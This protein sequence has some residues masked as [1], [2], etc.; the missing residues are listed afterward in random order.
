MPGRVS[1]TLTYLKSR[2][3]LAAQAVTAIVSLGVAYD[4]ARMPIQV[5]DSV[6]LLLDAQQSPSAWATFRSAVNSYGYLRPAFFG[7][8]KLLFDLS[9]GHYFLAFRGFHAA[10]I[11]AF[12]ALFVAALR[13]RTR[14]DL[15]LL[16]LALAVFAGMHT[17]LGT[18]KEAY[19]IN[20]YL[21]TAVLALAAL[22]LAQSRG[23]WLADL[24]AAVVF[25]VA[26]LTLETGLLVWV[27]LAA[28]W[29]LGMRGVSTRGT[30][31]VTLLLCGYLGFRVFYLDA[32]LPGLTERS[33]GFLTE[34][35]E[36]SQIQARFGENPLP[37]Y[38]YN[39]TS[40]LS[41]VLLSQPRSGVWTLAREWMDGAV[42]PRTLINL[43]GSLFATGLLGWYMVARLRNRQWRFL[44]LTDRQV[45]IAAAVI[46]A[47]AA[48]CFSYTKDEIMPAAGAFYA[49]AVFGA[50]RH[51]V[52]RLEE[53]PLPL[54]ATAL[55]TVVCLAGSAAWATGAV[56]VHHIL[57][58]QAFRHANDWAALP[59]RWE[60]EGLK[61]RTLE[62]LELVD[63]LRRDA[64][65]MPVPSPRFAS[66][67]VDQVF[68]A[69]Y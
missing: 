23:G 40:S 46:L 44:T 61:P 7:Q 66:R 35:L 2:P 10:L 15:L 11:V 69:D 49:V 1:P 22:N 56:G 38:A 9:G 47:N 8:V 68:D 39:V 51:L 17:F 13:I 63:T 26:A 52:E 67:W 43:A 5:Y 25:V 55:L 18:V 48:L 31:V 59:L 32:A 54:A 45:F 53:R 16:P 20:H 58:S 29:L 4:L 57:R 60:R 34:R 41:S 33:S 42:P 30:A 28:A 3:A 14:R 36:A 62:G 21:E 19:P 12:F 65:A 24:A 50:A 6:L 64:V 37:F 27:V